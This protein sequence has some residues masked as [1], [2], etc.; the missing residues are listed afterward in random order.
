MR[1]RIAHVQNTVGSRQNRFDSPDDA[2]SRNALAIETR[3]S[4]AV[5]RACQLAVFSDKLRS[6]EAEIDRKL[7]SNLSSTPLFMPP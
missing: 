7:Q 1:L 4:L 6:T 2:A 5:Y 3:H